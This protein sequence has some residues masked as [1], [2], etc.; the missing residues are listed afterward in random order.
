MRTEIRTI[1]VSLVSIAGLLLVAGAAWAQ[2]A[3]TPIQFEIYQ[4]VLLDEAERRWVDED[5][6][7]HARN[8]RY[9]DRLR[10]DMIGRDIAWN[11]WDR[12]RT[13]G[14]YFENGYYTFTGRI[15]GGDPTTGYGRYTVEGN[16]I[17]G[18]W[19]YTSDD[20]MHLEDGGLV[21]ASGAWQG[22][23]AIIYSGILLETQGGGSRQG[24]RRR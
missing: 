1:E 24:P 6:V 19:H 13:N 15:L 16:R 5:G 23:E 9:R 7:E 2:A 3:K 12:D 17:E 4:V 22:G 14:Y 18:V 11:N 8:E 21:K 10:G 20:V